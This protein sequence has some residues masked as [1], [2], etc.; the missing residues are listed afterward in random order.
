MHYQ[1]AVLFDLDGTLTESEEGI[2]GT[3][4]MAIEAVGGTVPDDATMRKFIGPPLLWSFHNL[5]G[6]SEDD[7][8]RAT[9]IY[10]ERYWSVGLFENRVYPGI[11]RLLKTLKSM[12]CWVAVAT[13]KP[14]HIS[15]RVVDHFGLRPYLD[16]LV[17]TSP[18]MSHDK[19]KIVAAALPDSFDEA[20]MV[21]DRSYDMDGGIANGI[22][23]VGAGWGY[24]G[25]EELRAA[26]CETFC[27]TVQSLIDL[28]CGGAPVPRGPF[29]SLEGPDG[30]G[31]STQLKLLRERLDRWGFEVV[32]SREPGG[33]PISEEIRTVTLDPKNREM[34]PVTEAL[35]Y[36]ASRAQHV[37]QVIRPTLASGRLLLSDRFV[38][39]S[40]AYQG[41]GREL[42]IELVRAINAPAVDGTLPDVTVYLEI[43]HRTALTR[44]LGASVPDRLEL[45]GEAFHARVEDAYHALIAREPE[46]FLVTD[47]ARKP[48]D[49]AEDIWARLF[50]RLTEA[51]LA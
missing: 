35:L 20:W 25:E 37:R 49:I 11:R 10:H 50:A 30:S 46:R 44:R 15:N 39:S 24:G 9:D 23:T 36:A 7:S 1:K 43:D 19:A 38:D 42:G 45:A 17:G 18:V 27:P 4:R 13:A 33:C 51:G 26:G 14:E 2:C 8:K 31:K 29:I 5:A 12:G 41:G 48:E 40:I 3:A 28:L 22:H 32:M 21:G 16:R 34:E 47:A 6:L